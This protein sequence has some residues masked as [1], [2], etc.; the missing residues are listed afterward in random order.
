MLVADAMLLVDVAEPLVVVSVSV[1]VAT[2][3]PE[4]GLAT[5]EVTDRAREITQKQTK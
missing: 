3:Q 1:A 2:A 5:C 4:L